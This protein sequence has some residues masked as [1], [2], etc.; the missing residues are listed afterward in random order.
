MNMATIESSTV[1]VDA[2]ISDLFFNRD[3]STI[4]E[5]NDD[6]D[7]GGYDEQKLAEDADMFLSNIR[8]LVGD[9]N[10]P[11]RESLINDFYGRL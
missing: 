10:T 7:F 8:G 4:V 9:E 5:K 11:S 3:F 1:S 2:D 6:G